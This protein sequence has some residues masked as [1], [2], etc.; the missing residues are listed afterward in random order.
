MNRLPLGAGNPYAGAMKT[1]SLAFSVH[2]L[3]G[4]GAALALMA[5]IAATRGDWRLMFGWLGLALIVD[6]IDGPL[7][8]KVDT[9]TH[10]PNWDGSLLDLVVDYLTYVF[11]PAYAL[12]YT[13]LLPAPWGLV[14]AL[15]I[16]LTAVVYF[17]DVRMKAADNCFVGFPAVWQMP[18][19]V[20]LVFSPPPWATFSIIV[21]LAIAQFT[22][23]KFIH[24][25]RTR[26]LRGVNLGVTLAWVVLAG[27]AIW[28]DFT[29][30]DAV[31][32]GL[33]GTSLWLIGIGLLM[34]VFPGR[35]GADP[36]PAAA[37]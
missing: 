5:L 6:G 3:T 21:L 13:D 32:W 34:Q 35:R 36:A 18:L 23:A 2:L 15:L 26:R 27:W 33:L 17:S 7:A 19:L 9:K 1:K 25:V 12:I 16:T 11:I 24:P 10:A 22:P 28:D 29:P 37:D 4:S 30:P 31:R 8:R 20:F 14:A